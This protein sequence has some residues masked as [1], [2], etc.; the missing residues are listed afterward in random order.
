MKPKASGKWMAFMTESENSTP[1]PYP[2]PFTRGEE[3]G[4]GITS[5]PLNS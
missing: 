2:L 3:K 5:Q 1:H 4:E